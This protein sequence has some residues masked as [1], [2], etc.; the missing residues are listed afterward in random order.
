MWAALFFPF[1]FLLDPPCCAMLLLLG[2][3]LTLPRLPQ[4]V[5]SPRRV[6]REW[7]RGGAMP[8]VLN[9]AN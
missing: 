3:N 7:D 1:P 8:C 5:T 6:V 9:I 2:W 4:Q